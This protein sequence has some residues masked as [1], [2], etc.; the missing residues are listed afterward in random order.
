MFISAKSLLFLRH[1]FENEG[2]QLY[3][4][5]IQ[6]LLF[7]MLKEQKCLFENNK[8]EKIPLLSLPMNNAVKFLN[9]EKQKCQ[10]NIYNDIKMEKNKQNLHF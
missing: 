1:S 5:K 9:S 2:S 6:Q 7:I 8:K 4:P 3:L 10:E